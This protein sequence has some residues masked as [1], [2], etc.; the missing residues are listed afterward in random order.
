MQVSTLSRRLPLSLSPYQVF[1]VLSDNG[2]QSHTALL[3]T[4]E[5]GTHHHKNSVSMLSAALQVKALGKTVTLNALNENGSFILDAVLGSREFCRD[6]LIKDKKVSLE[7]TCKGSPQMSDER[8]RLF[9]NTTVSVLQKLR[10]LIKTEDSAGNESSML[11]GAFSYE[12]VEQYETLPD[13]EKN[14]EDY[15]FY[16]ADQLVVQS[17][18]NQNAKI[19]VKGFGSN[20][21]NT[22]RLGVELE[23]I[24][25]I[26]KGSSVSDTLSFPATMGN[27]EIALNIADKDFYQKVEEARERIK[28]GDIF[29]VVLSRIFSVSCPNPFQAYGNLRLSNPSPYMYFINFGDKELFGASPESALKVNRQR[30]VFLYPIAGTR[31]RAFDSI[32]GQIN[33]DQDSRIEFEL[34]E[35]IKENAEHMMLVDLARNDLAKIV[36]KG[37]REVIQLKRV[38]KYSHVQHMVSEVKGVL[39]PDIDSLVAYRACANMGTLTGAPKIK[40]MEII[41]QQEDK[42]RG[43]YGGAVCTLNANDE[44]DSAI[45]IRSAV[46]TDGVAE[47]TAGAGVVHDSIPREEALETVNKAKAVID[48]CRKQQINSEVL[49]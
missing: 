8:E 34:I 45:I 13:I 1:A 48:A 27:T 41:R 35:D 31:K 44:F 42:A 28:Q 18:D 12:V 9:E 19:I 22:V 16:I 2:K 49:V 24:Y 33:H 32:T 39:K 11:I 10:D 25:Q 23:Q 40:A 47:I 43:Y 36:E 26:L 15:C 21:D 3:E 46:V 6:F 20:A 38:I 5:A 17:H 37:T 30:E 29:Q 4:A 7:L 14:Q